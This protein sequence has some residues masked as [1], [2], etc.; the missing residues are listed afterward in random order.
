[1]YKTLTNF[2]CISYCWF[3]RCVYLLLIPCSL[4]ERDLYRIILNP[5]YVSVHL[6]LR[7]I[8][9]QTKFCFWKA[10]HWLCQVFVPLAKGFPSS[11]TS[12]MWMSMFSLLLN[13]PVQWRRSAVFQKKI[14]CL[15]ATEVISKKWDGLIQFSFCILR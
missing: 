7:L 9:T 10:W 13:V 4:M 11:S 5:L 15:T 14:I 12:Y 3:P 8:E 6:E 2:F 1:M